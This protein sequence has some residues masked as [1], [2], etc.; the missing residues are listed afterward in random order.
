VKIGDGWNSYLFI[1]PAMPSSAP[2]DDIRVH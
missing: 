1:F 2:Q